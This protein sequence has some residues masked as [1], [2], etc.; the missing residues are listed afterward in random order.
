MGRKSK[1]LI[2]L[3]ELSVRKRLQEVT[4]MMVDAAIMVKQMV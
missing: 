3:S 4:Q 1:K 2:H